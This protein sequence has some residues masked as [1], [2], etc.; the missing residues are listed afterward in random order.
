MLSL[1]KKRLPSGSSS[2]SSGLKPLFLVEKLVSAKVTPLEASRSSAVEPKKKTRPPRGPLRVAAGCRPSAQT[3]VVQQRPPF[4]V[5]MHVGTPDRVRPVSKPTVRRAV[6][7]PKPEVDRKSGLPSTRIPKA[8]KARLKQSIAVPAIRSPKKTTTF[9]SRIPVSVR[10]PSS[11]ARTPAGSPPVRPPQS[12]ARSKI[13]VLAQRRSPDVF[14]AL[15]TSPQSA[16]LPRT[17]PFL[18]PRF[19]CTSVFA[20][21]MSSSSTGNLSFNAQ[22]PCPSHT[23]VTKARPLARKDLVVESAGLS[24]SLHAE[25]VTD[26]IVSETEVIVVARFPSVI[27]PSSELTTATKTDSSS[28][29]VAST[30]V[31]RNIKASPDSTPTHASPVSSSGNTDSVRRPASADSCSLQKTKPTANTTEDNSIMGAFIGELKSRLSWTK[32]A[33][34]LKADSFVLASK[35]GCR[36]SDNDNA[37]TEEKSELQQVLALRRQAIA[38]FSYKIALDKQPTSPTESRRPLAPIQNRPANGVFVGTQASDSTKDMHLHHTAPTGAFPSSDEND[39]CNPLGTDLTVTEL[40]TT[41]F[42]TRRVRRL[43]I[44]PLAEGARP[45]RDPRIVAELKF[46]RAKQKVGGGAKADKVA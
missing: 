30:E 20:S 42:G 14:S 27:T 45:S 12:A 38:G 43:V 21:P 23:L 13:P 15:R 3:A 18:I 11:L 9:R 31:T 19:N 17:T 29:Q 40:V 35:S 16:R 7:P 10:R 39:D 4:V 34:V 24:Q 37:N 32:A 8:V 1:L 2:T 6:P 22:T 28:N 46:L 33:T 36:P 25:V 26:S 5:S 41:A 44:P